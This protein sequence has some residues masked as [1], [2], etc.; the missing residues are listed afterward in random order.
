MTESNAA[1]SSGHSEEILAKALDD[2]RLNEA[3]DIA[4]L[5]ILSR[6]IVNLSPA[7]D[8]VEQAVKDM[9]GLAMERGEESA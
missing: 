1:N 4:L 5:E 6:H 2:L 7:S 8:A 9:E 3:T